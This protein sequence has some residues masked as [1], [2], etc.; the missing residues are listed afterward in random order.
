MVGH[1]PK[2]LIELL[3]LLSKEEDVTIYA[4]GTDLMVVKKFKEHVAFIE[5]IPELKV[6]KKEDGALILGAGLTYDELLSSEIPQIM[7]DVF[8]MIASPAIRNR[9][10]IGGNICNAS[11]AGDSLPMWYALSASVVLQ[12]LGEDGNMVMRKLPIHDF[13][14]G[15]RKLD[16][17]PNEVLTQIHIPLQNLSDDTLFYYKK[18]GARRAEAISKLSFFGMA[19]ISGDTVTDVQAAFGAVGIT[20]VNP[21]A[22]TTLIVGHT[23]SEIASHKKEITDAYLQYVKPIDDQRSN[24]VYRKQTATNLFEYFIDMIVNA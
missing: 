12:S 14:L 6:I 18:V 21:R 8:T 2:S 9:G 23:K 13:I 22:E 24:A 5:G 3:T 1:N 4:G 15:I 11:P 7:K 19:K 10:T 20:V 16:R 17:H